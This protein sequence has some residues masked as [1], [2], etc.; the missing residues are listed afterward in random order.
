MGFIVASQACCFLRP[1]SSFSESLESRF[2]LKPA[3][4]PGEEISHLHL[5][6][7]GSCLN[8][9]PL[10]CLSHWTCILLIKHQDANFFSIIH[11]LTET[12]DGLLRCELSRTVLFV[13]AAMPIERRPRGCQ[14]GGTASRSPAA[15]ASQQH[16]YGPNLGGQC[17]ACPC[18]QVVGNFS[19]TCSPHPLHV[20]RRRP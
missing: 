16:L 8:S 5:G 10:F 17:K 20:P 4:V 9:L 13:P 19:S 1:C 11:P 12:H 15:L 3:A 6:T 18:Q 7:F 2:D 14:E